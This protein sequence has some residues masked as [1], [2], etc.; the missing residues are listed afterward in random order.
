M[1]S[2]E[3]SYWRIRPNAYVKHH[4]ER[5]AR[6]EARSLAN[7]LHK[8]LTEA[9]AARISA[10]NNVSRLAALLTAVASDPS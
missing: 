1:S 9:V 6:D 5:I 3:E 8:L 2:G 7:T 4:V 10:D